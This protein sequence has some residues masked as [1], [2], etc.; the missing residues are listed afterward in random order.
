MSNISKHL[1]EQLDKYI[2]VK[3]WFTK[4][5]VILIR[6]SD[7]VLF[8]LVNAGILKKEWKHGEIKYYYSP[9]KD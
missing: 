1:Q 9:K 2:P 5:D 6:R 4:D 8:K 7:W 3:K